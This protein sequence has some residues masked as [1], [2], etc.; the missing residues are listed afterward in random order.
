VRAPSIGKKA[1]T[2]DAQKRGAP[3]FAEKKMWDLLRGLDAHFRRQA[4]VDRFTVDFVCRSARLVIEVDGGVHVLKAER[5]AARQAHI[6]A[7]GYRVL[8]FANDAVIQEASAVR[9]AILHALDDTPTPTP[10]RKGEGRR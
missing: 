2:A 4:K 1:P 3:T 10:P 9:A 7:L 5:D 8:R 6:E